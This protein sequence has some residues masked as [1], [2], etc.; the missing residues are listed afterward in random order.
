MICR[1]PFYFNRQ[2]H[3]PG[4]VSYERFKSLSPELRLRVTPLPCGRCIECRI[5]KAKCW[6]TRILLENTQ[7][8]VSCFTTLTYCDEALPKDGCLNKDDLTLFMK[9]LRNRVND[10]IRFF[11]VGEYGEKTLRPHFHLILFGVNFFDEHLILD[12]WQKGHI[13]NGEVTAASARYVTEY[14]VKKWTKGAFDR[15]DHLPPEF[16]RSSRGKPGG[17]GASALGEL[18]RNL[19]QIY[20]LKSGQK[21]QGHYVTTIRML[22]KIWPLDRYMK[23]KLNQLLYLDE[24][25]RRKHLYDHQEK[26]FQEHLTSENMFDMRSVAKKNRLKSDRKLRKN[27]KLKNER[28]I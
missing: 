14:C 25:V 15:P 19:R 24:E 18:S 5:L 20:R 2:S 16:M 8:E 26:I 22:G 17:I 12:S 9:K 11:A 27:A 7:H 4:L 21:Y 6:A 3:G 10:Q 1:N 13:Q 28:M 23:T